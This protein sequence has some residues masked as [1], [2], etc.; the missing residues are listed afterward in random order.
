MYIPSCSDKLGVVIYKWSVFYLLEG[1]A[2]EDAGVSLAMVL[3]TVLFLMNGL[4]RDSTVRRGMFFS[5]IGNKRE[6]IAK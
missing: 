6:C 2:G 5:T 1:V 3:S 4:T